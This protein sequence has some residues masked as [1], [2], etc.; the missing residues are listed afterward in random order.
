MIN[1]TN[2]RETAVSH[3]L[4]S[5]TLD[6]TKLNVINGKSLL[7][8]VM[9]NIKSNYIQPYGI[10]LK[11][12]SCV[13]G[14]FFI[15]CVFVCQV[16]CWA[17]G[18]LLYALVY[19]SMPFDGASH[20]MLTEQ[21]SQGRYRRPNPPSGTTVTLSIPLSINVMCHMGLLCVSLLLVSF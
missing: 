14:I 7:T 9:L 2:I 19:S 3:F 18:V 1:C 10:N 6:S 5:Q 4:K 15:I 11:P 17:L 20:T 12:E 13:H 8:F 21:I 16:D